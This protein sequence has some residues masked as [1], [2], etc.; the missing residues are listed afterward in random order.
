MP[1]FFV[2]FATNNIIGSYNMILQLLI[3][4]LAIFSLFMI[5]NYKRRRIWPILMFVLVSCLFFLYFKGVIFWDIQEKNYIW[6]NYPHLY[7]KFNLL[8]TPEMLK[9]L[10]YVLVSVWIL[11]WFNA[12]NYIDEHPLSAGNVQ[13]LLLISF[14]FMFSAQDFM[15]LMASSCCFSILGF[16]QI[17]DNQ[18]KTKFIFYSFASEMAI[19]TALAVVYAKMNSISLS[20]L[21]A[22]A[23]RGWHKDLVSV[24]ILIGVFAKCGMFLFQ[25]QLLDLCNLS[26]NR[27]LGA[28]FLASPLSGLILYFKLMPLIK[29]SSCASPIVLV[30]ISLSFLTSLFGMWW[31]NNYKNK[32]LY[33]CMS[34]FAFALSGI[35]FDLFN[36]Y[37]IIR[38]LPFVLIVSCCLFICLYGQLK[39][40]NILFALLSVWVF[41]HQL[42][43]LQPSN[44]IYLIL[45]ICG[46]S[47]ILHKLAFNQQDSAK[48]SLLSNIADYFLLILV[49][50]FFILSA[51]HSFSPLFIG[52][53]CLFTILVIITP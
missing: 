9:T 47:V 22:Y 28:A 27:L 23:P 19:F 21:G 5:V 31:H 37:Q 50:L 14:I 41:I 35:H 24:L 51:K 34:F 52:I 18:A 43:V 17:N 29:V 44:F 20:G 30:I 11:L 33:F 10:N 2:I 49:G 12:F 46:L 13:L 53:S 32:V 15:Q 36:I 48:V 8:Y 42:L 1:L 25:N 6:L 3:G 4:I 16:Y 40:L 26:A 38:F 7:S 45:S 39:K